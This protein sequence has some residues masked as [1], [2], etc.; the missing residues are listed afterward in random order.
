MSWGWYSGG[1]D[2]AAGVTNGTGWTN[3]PTPGVCS[4]PNHNP[5]DVYPYCGDTLFQY[6]HQPF[7]Y[8][9]NYA[10]GASGRSHLQDEQDFLQQAAGGSLPAVSFIKPL[11][12]E[13]E[14][15]GYTDVTS[16]EQHLVDL[17]KAIQAGPDWE[18]TAIV[19]TYDEHGG[20]WITSRRRR[21]TA[22]ATSGARARVC[23]RW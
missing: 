4:D 23:R 18:H 21:R 7:N 1:W 13:N 22:S 8:F 9:A 15:P 19:V 17:I 20:F 12:P 2:N 5:A 3:G 14:H 6:H 16:G 10:E 11:G